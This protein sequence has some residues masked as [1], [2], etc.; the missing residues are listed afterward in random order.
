MDSCSEF[1]ESMTTY[2][3]TQG[4]T[5]CKTKPTSSDSGST[6][7]IWL[8]I[9]LIL[10]VVGVILYVYRDQAKLYWFQIKT[11][12]KKDDGKNTKIISGTSPRIPPRPGFPPVRSP[13]SLSA[14][15]PRVARR[16]VPKKRSYDRRDKAMSDTFRK[17]RDISK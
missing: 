2:S 5:C 8:L 17:L 10:I 6:W 14:Q 16:L 4:Q 15:R 3:C 9:I 1:Q 13:R 12:F 11:K 7:W